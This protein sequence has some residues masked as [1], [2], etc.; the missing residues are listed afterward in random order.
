VRSYVIT[1]F[2]LEAAEPLL[3][4]LLLVYIYNIVHS[5]MASAGS[6]LDLSQ[7]DQSIT[8]QPPQRPDQSNDIRKSEFETVGTSQNS[9]KRPGAKCNH[10][11]HEFE[12][13]AATVDKLKQHI[14]KECKAVPQDVRQHW[15]GVFSSKQASS[16]AGEQAVLTGVKRKAQHQQD[17]RRHLGSRDWGL[18]ASEKEGVSF[19]LL[20]FAVTANLGFQQFNNVHLHAALAKLRPQYSLPSPTAFTRLLDS[21]Y[22]GVMEKLRVKISNSQNLTLSLDGWTDACKR[23]II[24][25]VLLFPDR[26]MRLLESRELSLDR[27]TGEFL[28]GGL[29]DKNRTARLCS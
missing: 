14:L 24:A 4:A 7:T 22:L 27:H 28:A 5:R 13:K 2:K 12:P 25:F 1:E 17:I 8:Q 18:T 3:D 6:N 23:S 15:L 9:S 16:T 11:Q 26:T 21:E 10:C 19:D 29:D 20:R